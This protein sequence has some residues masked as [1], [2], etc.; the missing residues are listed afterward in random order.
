MVAAG[1]IGSL[2]SVEHND[3]TNA[4]EQIRGLAEAIGENGRASS[5]N[6]NDLMGSMIEKRNQE[7]GGVNQNGNTFGT[8]EK[9]H[10]RPRN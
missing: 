1:S 3:L 10:E 2:G 8:S 9:L 7:S 6:N 4:E 5:L